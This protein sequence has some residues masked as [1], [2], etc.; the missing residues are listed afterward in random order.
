MYYFLQAVNILIQVYTLLIVASAVMSFFLSPYD[1][2]RRFI[3]RL[4]EPL[5][6]PIRKILPPMGMFDFSPLV[7]LIIMQLVGSLIGSLMNNMR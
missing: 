2:I 5:L 7:L 3:D 6:M 4:V 1:P